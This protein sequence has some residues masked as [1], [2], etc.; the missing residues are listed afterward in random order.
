MK[1]KSKKGSF[2]MSNVIIS[3]H[4]QQRVITGRGHYFILSGGEVVL[5]PTMTTN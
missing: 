1:K 3:P 4:P 5:I 2:K